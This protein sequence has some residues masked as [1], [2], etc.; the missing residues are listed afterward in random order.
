M[1]GYCSDKVSPLVR[2]AM[3]ISS[4]YTLETFWMENFAVAVLGK[5]CKAVEA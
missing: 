4:I 3:Y 2:E 1:F 5:L